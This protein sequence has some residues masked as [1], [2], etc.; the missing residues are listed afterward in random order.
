MKNTEKQQDNLAGAI[1][2]IQQSAAKA[3]AA[4]IQV[5]DVE[6]PD[7]SGGDIT[8]LVA[9]LPSSDGGLR[10][11]AL[12]VAHAE[13]ARAARELRLMGAPGPDRREGT[14]AHQALASFIDHI[15][16]FKAPNSAVWADPEKRRIVSIFDYH[17]EGAESAARWGKHRGVYPCPLS[18]AWKAWGG[19]QGLVLDQEQFAELL[20]RRDRELRA[21]SFSDGPQAGKAAPPPSDLITLA[22]QLETFSTCTVKRERDPNSQRVKLTATEDKGLSVAPPAAF[23]IFIRVFEDAHPE[24]LEVRL[25]VTV[26]EGHAK[27]AVRIHEAGEVLKSSFEVVCDEVKEKTDLPLFFGT[28]EAA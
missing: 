28:S 13:G 4:P 15:N 3:A 19:E 20:D 2:L 11:V 27:F 8:T 14:A 12:D 16:R 9:I 23:L 5:V 26:E 7:G 18:E 17:P 21:G 6:G 25:R 22:G 24:E 10:T 1:A